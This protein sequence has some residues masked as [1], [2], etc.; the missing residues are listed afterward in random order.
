MIRLVQS[1]AHHWRRW[2]ALR[3]GPWWWE[4]PSVN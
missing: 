3:L 1:V 2:H 4:R